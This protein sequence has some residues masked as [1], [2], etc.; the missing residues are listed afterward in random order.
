VTINRTW[1]EMGMP[2]SVRIEDAGA[3]EDDINLIAAWL[4]EVNQRFSTYL[5]TSEVS[6]L[7]D[8]ALRPDEI[9]DQF[10]DVLRR[11]DQTTDQTGGY[12]DIERDG[13]IDPS[14]LVKGWAIQEASA[15]LSARGFM[16]HV[17]EAGG[18]IQAMGLNHLGEPWRVGIR[19]PFKR[20]EQV[21]VL[22][23]SNLGVATSGTAIRGAHIYEP[24]Q[25]SPLSTDLVSLTV[26]APS[27]YDADRFA[28]AA[29]AMG[30][31]G[32]VFI[33]NQP[34]LE[35]Y[36]ITADGIATYTSGFDQYVH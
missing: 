4:N 21:K 32:L 29:F 5:P 11:C 25:P 36:A 19:N 15:K 30:R 16:N 33:A 10:A 17:V 34:N 26:V 28:T 8:G 35:G 9:S 2:V 13:K 3:G 27:I 31:A 14:G 1:L 6:R 20:D 23:V 7:N 24:R 18:D 12:F 22:A